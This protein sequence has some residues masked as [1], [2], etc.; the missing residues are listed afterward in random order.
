M[1]S[2]FKARRFWVAAVVLL[3]AAVLLWYRW[4]ARAEPGAGVRYVTAAVTR[5][6][7]VR[8]VNT[9]GQLTPWV[10]VEV[11]SQISGLVT[12]VNA[13][14]NTRVKKGQVLARI[15]P[16]TFEQTLRQAQ[17][18]LA[19]AEANHRLVEL[20]ARRLKGLRE[21]DLITQREYD[22]VEAQL[23]QSQ[24]SLLTARA[25]VENARV[26]L[27]RTTIASP[28]DGVVIFKQVEVG[29]T[30]AASLSAPTLFVIAQDLSRMRII[31]PVS[32]V[33]VWLVEPG[34]DVTFTVDALPER[35]FRGRLTQIRNPYTPSDQQQQQAANA[36]SSIVSFDAV[37]EVDNP[38]QLLRPSLTANV[39]I[40]V[41]RREGVL[42]VPNSALRVEMPGDV[43][44]APSAVAA[45]SP[46]AA[47]GSDA[48]VVVYRLA[49]GNPHA[50][51]E[52]VAVE[53]GISDNLVTEVVA[54][55]AEGD[56]V[57]TGVVDAP[58]DRPRG[59]L[60]F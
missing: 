52:A 42:R 24:A 21:Q 2:I 47:D 26:E 9:A 6:D 49:A 5:G 43:A 20:N 10:S 4:G 28:I 60:S 44:A 29:K 48:S 7:V 3:A 45:G 41:D 30:V 23:Q 14:F 16:A 36:A 55:L 53:L 25:T 38:D 27:E 17:A 19:A 12:E 15:D 50:R 34:Q 32:E 40:V 22:E 8:A 56:Q 31:A 37:I 57:V 33:D 59:R 13:D 35:R 1:L 46:A 58:T 11:S 51:P 39:E 18:N 54:G